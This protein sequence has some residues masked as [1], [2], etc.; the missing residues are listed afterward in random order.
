M[1]FGVALLVAGFFAWLGSRLGFYGSWILLWNL[2]LSAWQVQAVATYQCQVYLSPGW[3][4]FVV[5]YFE[6]EGL[7]E[8]TYSATRL[9]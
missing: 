7:A 9:H 2:V 6:A 3:H 1:I 8:I 4:N 5:E